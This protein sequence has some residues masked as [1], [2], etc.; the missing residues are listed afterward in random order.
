M[1]SG[2]ASLSP[3]GHSPL[4]A[5]S[6]A[7][8]L[9]AIAGAWTRVLDRSSLEHDLSFED[10]GGDS[11]DLLQFT[12]CLEET[13]RVRLPLEL[14]HLGLKPSDF[15]RALNRPLEAVVST[16]AD[17]CLTVFLFPGSYGFD[18]RLAHF[19]A[20]CSPALRVIG[21][22]YPNWREMLQPDFTFEKIVAQAVAYISERA[23]TGPL[24]IVGHSWGGHAAYAA[25][26]AFSNVGRPI[27][28]LGMLDT[29]ANFEFLP[30]PL[31]LLVERARLARILQDIWF[32]E[33][34]GLLRRIFPTSLF[35][36]PGTKRLLHHLARRRLRLPILVN[37]HFQQLVNYSLRVVLMK[38]WRPAAVKQLLAVPCFVFRAEG[39]ALDVPQ[40]LGWGHFCTDVTVL[41]M[42]GGHITMFDGRNGALLCA[43]FIETVSQTGRPD[44]K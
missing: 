14:F 23:P 22:P 38:R 39:Y 35:K 37:Y 43:R 27:S 24:F 3:A 20:G 11:L 6:S 1:T 2:Q 32:G 19:G 9:A 21:I 17:D 5:E 31:P 15:L 4:E 10:A 13:L 30:K 18:P 8:S 42:T 40:D 16:F 34:R 36:R 28:F 25:A 12:F 33:W 7:H 41:P 26:L 29:D 44:S